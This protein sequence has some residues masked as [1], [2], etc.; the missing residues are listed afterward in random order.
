MIED[1]EKVNEVGDK[2]RE[3][4]EC[5]FDFAEAVENC[6]GFFSSEVVRFK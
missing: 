4:M 6:S 2:I 1:D 5:R 3:V